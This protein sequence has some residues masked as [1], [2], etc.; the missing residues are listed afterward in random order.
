[1]L[2]PRCRYHPSCS[3]YGLQAVQRHGAIKGFLLTTWRVLRCN[4]F[5]GGGVDPVPDTGRWLPNV[6]PDGRM[7]VSATDT[8]APAADQQTAAT[9]RPATEA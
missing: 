4:P 3:S 8:V 9:T 5:S 6:Y 1:M 7:R 2:A